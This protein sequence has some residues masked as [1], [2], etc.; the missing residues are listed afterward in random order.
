M[1]T[2]IQYGT[3]M[4]F[5]YSI[6]LWAV[7]PEMCDCL[8]S[9]VCGS[10]LLPQVRGEFCSGQQGQVCGILNRVLLSDFCA[11][12][13]DILL[14]D[15]TIVHTTRYLSFGR[16]FFKKQRY[17]LIYIYLYIYVGM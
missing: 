3:N 16:Y 17:L 7:E 15:I 12:L 1:T 2:I 6:Y 13:I 4:V 14:L 11:N 9:N 5:I 10:K 8:W